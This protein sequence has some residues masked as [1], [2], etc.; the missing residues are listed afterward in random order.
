MRN[1]L[2]IIAATSLA[3][4]SPVFAGSDELPSRSPDAAHLDSGKR[5]YVVAAMGDSLTDP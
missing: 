4:A 5:T 1:A 3:L 2:P